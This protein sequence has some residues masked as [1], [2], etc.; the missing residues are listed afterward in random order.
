M[1]A[2]NAQA[3]PGVYFDEPE[4]PLTPGMRTGA[5]AFLGR[6][7]GKQANVPLRLALWTPG[8]LTPAGYLDP[9]GYLAA[10]VHGFFANGGQQ[11]YVVPLAEGMAP[12]QALQG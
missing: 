4:R 7:P 3:S 2:P 9:S 1:A 12:L 8:L 10:A 5:P 6:A 11:C